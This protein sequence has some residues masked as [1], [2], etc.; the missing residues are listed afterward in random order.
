[1]YYIHVN[2]KIHLA[3]IK[4]FIFLFCTFYELPFSVHLGLAEIRLSIHKDMAGFAHL[5]IHR[6]RLRTIFGFDNKKPHE[7][8]TNFKNNLIIL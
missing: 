7:D 6:L 8:F 2:F 3:R 4:R 5:V 1:M